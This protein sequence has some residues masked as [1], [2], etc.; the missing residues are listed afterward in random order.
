MY[1]QTRKETFG[2]LNSMLVKQFLYSDIPDNRFGRVNNEECCITRGNRWTYFILSESSVTFWLRCQSMK[3][4]AM[5]A[6]TSLRLIVRSMTAVVLRLVMLVA[7]F[8]RIMLIIFSGCE[9][10][11]AGY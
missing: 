2:N 4:R 7:Q 9:A 3:R 8:V 6:I 5:L 11:L 10:G 1:S